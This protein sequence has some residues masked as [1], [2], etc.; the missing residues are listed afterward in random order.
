M[1]T[2]P[3]LRDVLERA[4][5]T[6]AQSL[7]AVWSVGVFDVVDLDWRAAAGVASGAALLSILKSLVAANVGDPGTASLVRVA[8]RHAKKES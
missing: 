4:I 3:Y 7:L 1:F 2:L 8:G 5:S 6:A